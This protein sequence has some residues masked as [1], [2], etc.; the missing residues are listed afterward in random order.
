M[1]EIL[2]FLQAFL[3]FQKEAN[4]IGPAVSTEAPR[5][6]G[7]EDY[8]KIQRFKTKLTTVPGMQTARNRC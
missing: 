8:M 4:G 2:C 7:W 5:E 1:F 6:N 3:L